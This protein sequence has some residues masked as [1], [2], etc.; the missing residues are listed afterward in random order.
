MEKA[1]LE[2]TMLLFNPRNMNESPLNIQDQRPQHISNPIEIKATPVFLDINEL[3]NS[4]NKPLVPVF[5]KESKLFKSAWIYVSKN[6]FVD[7]HN[8]DKLQ[9]LARAWKTDFQTFT[10]DLSKMEVTL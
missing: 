7:G 10:K 8:F 3:T 1:N 9:N 2:P 4:N 6:Q 5:S